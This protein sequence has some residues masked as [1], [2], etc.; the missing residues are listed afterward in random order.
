MEG[1]KKACRFLPSWGPRSPGPISWMGAKQLPMPGLRRA[2]ADQKDS[3]QLNSLGVLA[4]YH[5]LYPASSP[6][7]KD[8]RPPMLCT[9]RPEKGCY[10]GQR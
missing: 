1:A 10:G 2:Y 5:P 9:D 3:W 8:S 7:R 6:L 4:P